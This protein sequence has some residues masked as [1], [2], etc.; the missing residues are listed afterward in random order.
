VNQLDLLGESHPGE[1]S[2][3]SRGLRGIDHGGSGIT[4][5][6]RS[7]GRLG[8]SDR[9]K[10][11]GQNT[12]QCGPLRNVAHD[13]PQAIRRERLTVDETKNDAICPLIASSDI[14]RIRFNVERIANCC[15]G[16]NLDAA[17]WRVC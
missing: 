10:R 17:A 14:T 2:V 5:A 11:C 16:N 7:A 6:M 3:H 15:G 13:F 4:R 8:R 12:E 1:Q 9:A